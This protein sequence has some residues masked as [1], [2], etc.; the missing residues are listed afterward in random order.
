MNRKIIIGSIALVVIAISY[1]LL[2]GF[3]KIEVDKVEV[4]NYVIV[5]LKYKGRYRSKELRTKFND[6]KNKLDSNI[7]QG[8]MVVVNYNL[9]KDSLDNGYI[10]QFIGIQ[11]EPSDSNDTFPKD[12]KVIEIETTS[13]IAAKISAHNVVMPSPEKIDRKIA[14]YARANQ[15]LKMNLSIEKYVSERELIVEAPLFD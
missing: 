3:D 5:G 10:R 7:V 2:G 14:E 11:I 8:Q 4:N 12:Y 15:L 1:I 6:V 13:A 9:D